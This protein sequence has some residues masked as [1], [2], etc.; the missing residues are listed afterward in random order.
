MNIFIFQPYHI[1]TLRMFSGVNILKIFLRKMFFC[2]TYLKLAKVFAIYYLRYSKNFLERFV[3][4]NMLGRFL[5]LS[6][7][8]AISDRH[9]VIV[10]AASNIK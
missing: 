1:N 8:D 4:K 10:I 7:A 9:Q 6:S 5:T 2:D 3:W